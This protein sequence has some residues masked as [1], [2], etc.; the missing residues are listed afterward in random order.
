MSFHLQLDSVLHFRSVDSTNLEAQRQRE[1]Y[2]GQ[3]VLYIADEQ[4]KGKGQHGRAWESAA[5]L[6][7]WASLFISK[8]GSLRHDLS[9][10]SHYVGVI[11]QGSIFHLG[12]IQPSLKWPNDIMLG[13]KKCGGILT[14]VQWSGHDIQSAIIGFGIN[15]RHEE[16]DFSPELRRFSTSLLQEHAA[17]DRDVLAEEI[18]TRFFEQIHL[19]N[20]PEELLAKW[21]AQ[22]WKLNEVVQWQQGNTAVTGIFQGVT[23]EGHARILVGS[24]IETF[25]SGEIRWM[26]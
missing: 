19:L 22:A 10:L 24:N 13:S 21:N 11:I 20:K 8:P 4:T 15:L 2:T 25:A 14:E 1:T 7:L 17:I 12:E 18:T 3:N 26:N 23:R 5:N 9:L 6:G 16:M